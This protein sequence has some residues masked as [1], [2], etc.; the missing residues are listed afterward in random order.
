MHSRWPIVRRKKNDNLKQHTLTHTH[1]KWSQ[2]PTMN[3][4]LELFFLY[5]KIHL[6]LKAYLPTQE[7]SVASKLSTVI[8]VPKLFR[9]K[10]LEFK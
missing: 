2:E 4:N 5:L 1:R 9:E 3:P 7:M 6:Y 8:K 10:L